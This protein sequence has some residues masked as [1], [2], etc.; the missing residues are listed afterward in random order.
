ML[1]EYNSKYF[2]VFSDINTDFKDISLFYTSISEFAKLVSNSSCF[3][4]RLIEYGNVIFKGNAIKN[5]IKYF[6]VNKDGGK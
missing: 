5:G 1:Y 2:L 3:Y 4:S 6:A